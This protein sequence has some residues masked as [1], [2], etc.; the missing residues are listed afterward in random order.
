M[1]RASTWAQAWRPLTNSQ[2]AMA[3]WLKYVEATVTRYKDVVN[4]WEIWNEPYGQGKDYAPLVM[5]TAELVKRIQPEAVI[6]GE[7]QHNPRSGSR[8]RCSRR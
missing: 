2:E 7:I 8:W 4:E 3:A 1:D 5:A 6:L